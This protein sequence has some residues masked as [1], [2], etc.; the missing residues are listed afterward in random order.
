MA[1][2][3]APPRGPSPKREESTRIAVA[4]FLLPF[5]ILLSGMVAGA[6]LMYLYRCD[7]VECR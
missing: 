1:S 5:A 4:G 6:S 3:K 2:A 7:A